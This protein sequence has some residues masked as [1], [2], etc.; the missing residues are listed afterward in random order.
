M[1]I[2]VC[3]GRNYSKFPGHDATPDELDQYRAERDT[4]YRAL[5]KLCD[6]FNLWHDPD[7]YGN[8]M[9]KDVV[10]ISGMASGVDTTAVDWAMVNWTSLECFPAEW[11]KYGRSAGYIRNKQMLDKGK[12]DIVL[13]GPG[14]RGTANM[15]DIAEKA[16]V[17]VRRFE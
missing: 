9:P 2:L 7:Q 1:R 16:G 6:E 14:G 12:P 3:G 10:I 15:I 13:A 17:E 8:T 4:V 5:Y 11:D